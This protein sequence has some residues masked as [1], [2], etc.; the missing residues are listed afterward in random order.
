MQFIEDIKN[1]QIINKSIKRILVELHNKEES[2]AEIVSVVK[3]LESQK[4]VVPTPK[5]NLVFDVCGTGGTGKQRINLSTAL[6]IRL[7]KDFTIAKH[8]NKASSGR[9]GSFDIIEKTDFQICTTPSQAQIE[10]EKNNLSFLFGPAFHPVLGLLVAIR[11]SLTHPTIFNSIGPLINPMS[12]LTAQLMGVK[13]V[14]TG[15]KLAKVCAKLGKNIL[16]V[17]DTVFGLDEVSIGGETHYFKV[18]KGKIQEGTFVP[19][20]FGVQRVSDFSD[21][22]GAKNI[23]DNLKIFNSL[24]DNTATKEQQVFLEVNYRVAKDFFSSFKK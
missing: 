24:L 14:K 22:E 7:A 23:T 8:G 18:L 20:D 12:D 13:D 2:V 5:N 10:L 9:F 4:I 16:L 6:A 17:H 21:I 11:K 15:R 19:E 1:L 3:F